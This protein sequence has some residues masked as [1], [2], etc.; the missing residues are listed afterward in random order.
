MWNGGKKMAVSVATQGDGY[1]ENLVHSVFAVR[2]KSWKI[3][4][5][6]CASANKKYIR[7]YNVNNRS[8]ETQKNDKGNTVE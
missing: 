5:P 2:R 1:H 8:V 6:S 4:V 7:R 3:L